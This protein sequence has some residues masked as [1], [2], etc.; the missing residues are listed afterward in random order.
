MEN[1]GEAESGGNPV[2]NGFNMSWWS[3]QNNTSVW[4]VCTAAWDVLVPL[5]DLRAGSLR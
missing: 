4:H 3:L 2:G 5:C 1:V